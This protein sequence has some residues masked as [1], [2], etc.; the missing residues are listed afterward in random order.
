[1]TGN[2][3]QATIDAIDLIMGAAPS[4]E[5]RARFARVAL[6]ILWFALGCAT[7]ALLYWLI[8]FWYLGVA[9]VVGVAVATMR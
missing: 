8:G 2:T 4:G 5:T 9:V 3:T 6:S 7:S 1:M